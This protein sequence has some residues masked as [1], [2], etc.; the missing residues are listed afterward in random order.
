MHFKDFIIVEKPYC[1]II[2]LMNILKDSQ[3][4]MSA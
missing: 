1:T 3:A 4:N 2:C